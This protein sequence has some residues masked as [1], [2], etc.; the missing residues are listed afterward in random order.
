MKTIEFAGKSF[1]LDTSG[2]L[3][4]P[5]QRVAVVAD[6]HLEKATYFAG[7]GQLLPPQES[8][9]TLSRLQSALNRLDCSSL[10]LLGDSFHDAAGL[11]R[12]ER[13]AR[14]L[15]EQICS[16]Y[17]VTFILGNHDGMVVPSQT[18]GANLLELA[19]VTFR[20]QAV[21]GASVEI[22][23]HYHPKAS[24]RLGGKRITRPC[25]VTDASRMILP[26]FGTLTGGLDVKS[27]AISELFAS[28][29]TAHLLGESKIYSV[30]ASRLV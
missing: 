27:D 13:R 12:L 23:G 30:P 18:Q 28:E 16:E 8:Y 29:F 20:H 11:D 22:S 26:S 3:I 5:D 9:E 7:Q 10:L 6:L 15:W 4:W 21:L 1:V 19:G 14:E 17:S 24:L 2:L 25:F